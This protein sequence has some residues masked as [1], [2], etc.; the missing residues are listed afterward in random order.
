VV[1]ADTLDEVLEGFAR[2]AAGS[3]QPLRP[4]T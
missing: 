3:E 4:G 2:R 1:V